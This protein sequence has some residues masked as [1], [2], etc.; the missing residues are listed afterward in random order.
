MKKKDQNQIE[1][2]KKQGIILKEK[3]EEKPKDKKVIPPASLLEKQNIIRQSPYNPKTKK[4]NN[5]TDLPSPILTR[6]KSE[7]KYK[8]DK[9]L[10]EEKNI[11][12]DKPRVFSHS[13][14]RVVNQNNQKPN[15]DKAKALHHKN[16]TERKFK[17]S[18]K[19]DNLKSPNNLKIQ[20]QNIL[21]KDSNE[22]ETKK[23]KEEKKNEDIKENVPKKNKEEKK[24][25]DIKVN[26]A[27]KTKDEKKTE[28]KK[29]K[30]ES[31]DN[32]DN[33][34]KENKPK[35]EEKQQENYDPNLYGFNLY[36]HI[37]E[38]LRNKD[39]LCKDKLTKETYYCIDC[40][41][42]TCK[43]CPDFNVHKGHTLVPKY[44]YYN[45]DENLFNDT[46]ECLD[47]LFKK[48]PDILDNNKLKEELKKKVTDTI[49][50]IVKRLNEIKNQKLKELDKLFEH[51]D[52]CMD[53]LKEKEENIKNDIKNYLEKQKD[54]YFLQIEEDEQSD[55]SLEPNENND[56]DY[57]VLK[58]LKLGANEG[59]AG[60]IESN[61]DTYN[62]TFLISYDLFKNTAFI[63]NEVKNLIDDI[64]TNRDKYL[65][66]YDQNLTQLN[67]DIDKF[68]QPFNG[69]FN[70]RFLTSEFYKMVSDKLNK[71]N[72]KIDSIR[73]Y[74]YDMVN[75]DGNFDKIDKDNRVSET[76]IKQR[77]DNILNYQ[78]SDKDEALSIRSKNSK[79]NNNLHR[80]SL[81]FNAGLAAAKLKNTL[82]N[83]ATISNVTNKND[84]TGQLEKI[85]E[86]PEDIKL[87]KDV[88]QKYFAYE[89]Y[90]TVHNNFRY[91][92]PKN[93]EEKIEEEFDEDND[94]AK[95]IPGTNEM[96]LYDKKST[97]LTKKIV[98]FEK[99]KHKY[100]YFLNGCRSVLVKDMLY[101]LGGVDKEKNTT[102]MAYVYYI[103]T[104][105]LKVM[106][107]MLKPHAY[108]SVEF[109]DYYK[110]IIVLGGENCVSCEL[111]DLNTGLWRALPD[112][113]VPR[114]HCNL[115]L[116]KFA[117]AIYTFFG[118]IGDITEKHN[119][120]D[121]I[122]VLELKRLA[123]GWSKIDYNNKA[124][125]D[126]KSGY[127]K[128]E[129]LSPEM[130]LIYGA[131]NMRDLIKKAAVYIIPKFEI[132]KIDNRIF[133]EIKENSQNSK[134]LSKILSSY[135]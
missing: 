70:Y 53:A 121:V 15:T 97:T 12:K 60:M 37:K 40:K 128:I 59:K 85:Y 88:L 16:L 61:K 32:K 48:N 112:M 75:K 50:N 19:N 108:H 30:K 114:A 7:Q 49:N 90:N 99:N 39:K 124:E 120:T 116:D 71:Y 79:A 102:K 117:H 55:K 83:Q 118:V 107:E 127:N 17:P 20:K 84:K 69:V 96:Q 11:K 29:D 113:N 28:E 68:S 18:I 65:D 5:L 63:N 92:K 9:R 6:K 100:T 95:P 131:T 89:T 42:S 38:N 10:L 67:E 41:I 2:K 24:N 3:T 34:E 93:D 103:K 31:R 104:N 110:S 77:F 13:P 44:L 57:D 52:G 101:I 122:E 81:Y 33:K 27:K 66:E 26:E 35:E 126:F 1:K 47:S 58:N 8:S 119:Y 4:N 80:L 82:K 74:I 23:I 98:K 76:Q 134:K 72:E 125:M 21:K 87:D 36:K 25:E 22:N 43:K 54:F 130:I 106:P 115:Y 135:I 105:E 73:K 123:L 14:D 56:A 86:R 94:I 64:Q 91:K 78:L 132:V 129:P 133:K 109:L 111:Y 45:C 51:T 46:F 62:S